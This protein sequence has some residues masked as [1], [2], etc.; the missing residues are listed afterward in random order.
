[1]SAAFVRF[2]FCFLLLG[3]LAACAEQTASPRA[4]LDR[5][6]IPAEAS[7]L[8]IDAARITEADATAGV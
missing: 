8:G 3:A 6:A 2:W 7:A 1:M 4:G 5:T